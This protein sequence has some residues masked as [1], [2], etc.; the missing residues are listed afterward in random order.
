MINWTCSITEVIEQ[1]Y[2]LLN[3]FHIRLHDYLYI[4]PNIRLFPNFPSSVNSRSI[5][6]ASS[7]GR[8]SV[9]VP[10]PPTMISASMRSCLVF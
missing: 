5:P 8:N 3:P 9:P 4:R 10:E 7:S 6:A 2:Y 1:L